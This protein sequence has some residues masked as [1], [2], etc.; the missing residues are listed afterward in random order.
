MIRTG[1][2]GTAGSPHTYS[3]SAVL[4]MSLKIILAT[5]EN[6][7]SS[8]ET[9]TT[10]AR[11]RIRQA[12]FASRVRPSLVSRIDQLVTFKANQAM[13]IVPG[14]GFANAGSL[15]RKSNDRAACNVPGRQRPAALFDLPWLPLYLVAVFAFHDHLGLAAVAGALAMAAIAITAEFVTQRLTTAGNQAITSHISM[16]QACQRNAV[17][18]EGMGFASNKARWVVTYERR[19]GGSYTVIHGSVE[20][21]VNAQV[22]LSIK[23]THDIADLCKDLQPRFRGFAGLSGR[24]ATQQQKR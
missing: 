1:R 22:V 19:P 5:I 24:H 13:I 6:A 12:F 20:G 3:N 15:E 9:V 23:G 4:I 7:K 16:L 14:F 8:I 17:L 18:L 21:D 11:G 10:F 2:A